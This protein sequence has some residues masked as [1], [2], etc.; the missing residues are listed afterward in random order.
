V[1][2]DGIEILNEEILEVS[3]DKVLGTV[4]VRRLYYRNRNKPR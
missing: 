1:A 3:M 4:A 2:I